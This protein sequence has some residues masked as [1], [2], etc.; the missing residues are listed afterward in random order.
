ML[1]VTVILPTHNRPDMFLQALKSYEEQDYPNKELI[2]VYND[3]SVEYPK[4]DG[5]KSLCLVTGKSGNIEEAIKIAEGEV[6]TL[7]HDDDL[8]FDSGS[9]T[10][11]MKPFNDS[12]DVEV[13]FTSF[14]TIDKDGNRTSDIKDCGNVSLKRLLEKE[15]IYYPTMAWRKEICSKFPV[16][17][18]DL[19][20]YGDLIFKVH[21]LFECNCM[22]VHE[23]TLLYRVHD[24]QESCVFGKDGTT[25]TERGLA[26]QKI[27]GIIGAC[28]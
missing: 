10:N 26:M 23:P 21:C 25:I 1:K 16:M 13:V 2:I 15:Y 17:E 9:L 8:F 12:K 11:R 4:V 24:G 19:R 22:P 5:Y 28:L 18:Y 20:A 14:Q 7:L 3:C 27:R 6:I